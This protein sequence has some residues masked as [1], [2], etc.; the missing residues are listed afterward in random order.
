MTDHN[1]KLKNFVEK[2]NN[3]MLRRMAENPDEVQAI[4]D[5]ALRFQEFMKKELEIQKIR[6]ADEA[7][8]FFQRYLVMI[9]GKW[10]FPFF[11][12]PEEIK[13]EAIGILTKMCQSCVTVN[14]AT[15]LTDVDLALKDELALFTS[16]SREKYGEKK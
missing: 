2:A 8:S 10:L 12:A 5:A 1:D 14:A 11:G 7:A 9:G 15:L 6:T 16:K 3:D 13:V 4:S